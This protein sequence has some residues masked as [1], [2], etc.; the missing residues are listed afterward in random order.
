[1]A[2]Y[3]DVK[4][5]PVTSAKRVIVVPQGCVQNGGVFVVFEGKARKRSVTTDGTS[6]KGVLVAS[7]LIGGEEIIVSPPATLKDGQ[8]VEVKRNGA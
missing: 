6:D 5:D 3:N 1:V 7:G 2:F 8:K 4:Q